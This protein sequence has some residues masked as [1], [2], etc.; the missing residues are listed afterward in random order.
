MPTAIRK[1]RMKPPSGPAQLCERSHGAATPCCDVRDECRR[2]CRRRRTQHRGR[3][4][5]DKGYPTA[6]C[7]VGPAAVLHRRQRVGH[8]ASSPREAR[9]IREHF[10]RAL[11]AF[12]DPALAGL[13]Y[14]SVEAAGVQ[15]TLGTVWL[16]SRVFAQAALMLMAAGAVFLE[17]KIAPA[18]GRLR[19]QPG[20]N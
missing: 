9:R 15:M 13:P 8:R 11:L 18:V 10:S 14:A 16:E 1:P 17:R 12:D 6:R 5:F 3:R 19:S 7:L 20:D 2:F 4:L